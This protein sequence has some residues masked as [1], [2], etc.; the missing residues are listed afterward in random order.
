VKA[1]NSAAPIQLVGATALTKTGATDLATALTSAVPS[2][3]ID[4]TGGDM[5]ALSI[6]AALRGLNPND[7]LVL[8]EC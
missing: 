3:N 2:L 8:V 7:T 5:A 6:Q 4:T 1:A